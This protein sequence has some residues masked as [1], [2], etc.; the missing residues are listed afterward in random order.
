M[1]PGI[2]LIVRGAT[3]TKKASLLG[4][5]RRGSGPLTRLSGKVLTWLLLPIK[6]F[7][8]A[9]FNVW[10]SFGEVGLSQLLCVDWLL[11][12]NV[13]SSEAGLSS[14]THQWSGHLGVCFWGPSV[15]YLKQPLAMWPSQ[16]PTDHSVYSDGLSPLTSVLWDKRK[17]VAPFVNSLTLDTWVQACLSSCIDKS[18]NA[19]EPQIWCWGP[20]IKKVGSLHS[21]LPYECVLTQRFLGECRWKYS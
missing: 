18:S 17:W 13:M 7:S 12:W 10:K 2:R 11:A 6:S 15:L 5:R 4:G 1:F 21:V 20:A 8:S 19:I 9:D 14:L 16:H 3:L